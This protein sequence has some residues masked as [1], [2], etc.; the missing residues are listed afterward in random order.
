M[1]IGAEDIGPRHLA[2]PIQARNPRADG[3]PGF[4]HSDRCRLL[5]DIQHRRH[6]LAVAGATAEHAAQGIL[7]LG[8]AR[9]GVAIEKGG[10]RHQHTRRAHA[11]LR[12]TMLQ[13]GIL[14]LSG[15]AMRGRQA[16]DGG[17]ILPLDLAE[18]DQAGTGRLA[19]HQDRAGTTITGI[20][21]DLGA[22]QAQ[23]ITQRLRKSPMRRGIHRDRATV[24][25]ERNAGGG[26]IHDQCP[27][28]WAKASLATRRNSV[29]A[30]S[31][32]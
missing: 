1:C 12:S 29:R 8:F 27:P 28:A 32:R 26:I 4:G 14:Q 6:D 30:A 17:D 20:A 13:K 21:T 22:F 31:W 15:N 3:M 10:R 16:F 7:H 2:L 23:G 19:V 18:G 9:A 24:E 25:D 11:A 5:P